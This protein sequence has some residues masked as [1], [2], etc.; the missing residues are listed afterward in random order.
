MAAY[1]YVSLAAAY[2]FHHVT[3]YVLVVQGQD[4]VHIVGNNLFIIFADL[5]QYHTVL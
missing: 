3:V 5:K 2:F 4:Q 1:I